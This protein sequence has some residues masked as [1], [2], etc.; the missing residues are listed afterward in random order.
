[1]G[2]LFPHKMEVRAHAVRRP[3]VWL[4][5]YMVSEW[6]PKPIFWE[7]RMLLRLH[8]VRQR[9]LWLGY[10]W[11]GELFHGPEG[12]IS[13]NVAIP[14]GFWAL[15]KWPKIQLEVIFPIRLGSYTDKLP[16]VP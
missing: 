12:R 11:T 1:M 8:I 2:E 7:S 4:I 6:G 16:A 5:V 15:L 13:V 14:V 9:T 10:L 3:I